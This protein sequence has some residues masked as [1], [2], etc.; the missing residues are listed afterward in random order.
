MGFVQFVPRARARQNGGALRVRVDNGGTNLGAITTAAIQPLTPT[1]TPT[2]TVRV[3]TA[4]TIT[5]PSTTPTSGAP[6]APPPSPTL[7][8]PARA[9]AKGY[10]VI[11]G[12][13]G[14]EYTHV[15]GPMRGWSTWKPGL[16]D[17]LAGS[18]FISENAAP[19][20]VLAIWAAQ[21]AGAVQPA[22]PMD[23]GGSAIDTSSPSVTDVA[24]AAA[25]IIAPISPIAAAAGA[26]APAIAQAVNADPSVD[27]RFTD[28]AE[29]YNAD[30]SPVTPSAKA[31]TLTDKIKA[32]PPAAKLGGAILLAVF[33]MRG[34]R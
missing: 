5:V 23:T 19:S 6:P 8:P 29:V 16:G 26:L 20:D 28:D 25:P 17:V 11:M 3:A 34:K 18:G 2:T 7:P 10:G 32:L 27:V 13:D 21:N 24:A 9:Y 31:A 12:S 15:N 22:A 1:T 30:G 33:F 4:P 14:V